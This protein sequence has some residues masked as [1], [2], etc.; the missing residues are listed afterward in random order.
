VGFY[1]WYDYYIVIA[2]RIIIHTTMRTFIPI[3]LISLSMLTVGCASSGI[4]SAMSILS[5]ADVASQLTTGKGAIDNAVSTVT[6]KDCAVFRLFKGK[7]ICQDEDVEALIDMG[8]EIY[9]W[10][11]NDKPYCKKEK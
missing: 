11:D 10:D 8:C 9:A 5:T 6:E 2:D 4:M 1:S 3:I 7:K